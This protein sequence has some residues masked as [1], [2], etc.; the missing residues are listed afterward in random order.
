MFFVGDL[1]AS[2][3]L[4]Q[5]PRGWR[6]GTR[7]LRTRAVGGGYRDSA[8]CRED[9]P[10]RLAGTGRCFR[11]S[12]EACR[13]TY[14]VADF[15]R[16]LAELPRSGETDRFANG[17]SMFLVSLVSKAEMHALQSRKCTEFY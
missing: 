2:R 4:I 11:D 12:L 5:C 9:R 14:L 7:N 1:R 10:P 8:A 13:A 16:N 6:K 15:E 3:F 17:L